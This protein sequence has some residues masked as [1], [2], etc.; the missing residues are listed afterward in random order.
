MG[1]EGEA[2]QG[3]GPGGWGSMGEGGEGG[4]DKSGVRGSRSGGTQLLASTFPFFLTPKAMQSTRSHNCQV[5]PFAQLD[6]L[7]ALFLCPSP[8]PFPPT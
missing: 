2:T 3:L 6:I 7:S 1:E 4:G 5:S 8:L